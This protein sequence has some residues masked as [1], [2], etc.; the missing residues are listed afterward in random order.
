[1][2]NRLAGGPCAVFVSPLDVYFDDFNFVQPDVFVV[3]DTSKVRERVFGAPDLVI[4]V[5][6]SSSSIR[7]KREKKDLY[8]R[9]GVKE[10]VI[11]Y[12]EEA[13]IERYVLAGS[14]YGEPDI[15]G[16]EEVLAMRFL[17]GI[18]IRLSEVFPGG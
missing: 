2:A 14:R 16:P 7:D 1:L 12:P 13:F 4:E 8:E 17:E 10:Y 5:L 15:L 11:A 18:E 6:S 3:C 9:F